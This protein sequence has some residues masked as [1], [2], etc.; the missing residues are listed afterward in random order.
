MKKRMKKRIITEIRERRVL[1]NALKRT[2]VGFI[3]E[4]YRLKPCL[5]ITLCASALMVWGVVTGL[6]FMVNDGKST[7]SYVSENLSFSLITLTTLIIL[8]VGYIKWYIEKQQWDIIRHYDY[9]PSKVTGLRHLTYLRF[10]NELYRINYLTG[11]QEADSQLLSLYASWVKQSIT[12]TALQILL[13]AVPSIII[14]LASADFIKAILFLTLYILV[15]ACLKI[16]NDIIYMYNHNQYLA[17]IFIESL[18]AENQIVL[19]SNSI[20]AKQL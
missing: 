6:L 10:K 12:T 16:V 14:I 20:C 18:L 17:R 11:K 15:F 19:P 4:F 9:D 2:K 7:M 1:M 13:A 8:L 5:M 3:T